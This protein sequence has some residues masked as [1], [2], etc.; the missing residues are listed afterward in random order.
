MEAEPSPLRNHLAVGEA[1]AELQLAA[2]PQRRALPKENV[3]FG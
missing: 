1:V 3:P 2:T